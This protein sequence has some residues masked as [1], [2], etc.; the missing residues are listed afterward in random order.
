MRLERLLKENNK[1]LKENNVMLN[2]IIQY[3]SIKEGYHHE[4]NNDDFIRNI[5]ANLISTRIDLK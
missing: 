2:Q 1:L 4:E 5:L 3:I